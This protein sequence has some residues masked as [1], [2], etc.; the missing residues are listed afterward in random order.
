MVCKINNRSICNIFDFR[1]N[2]IKGTYDQE[3]MLRLFRI[4]LKPFPIDFSFQDLFN[5]RT[6]FMKGT[7][8]QE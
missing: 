7:D 3:L 1:I 5:I 8:D 6:L 2:F 4:I